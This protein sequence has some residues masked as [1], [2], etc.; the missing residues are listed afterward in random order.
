MAFVFLLTV[1][2]NTVQ[3]EVLTLDKCIEIGLKNN[4]SVIAAKNSYSVSGTQVYSAWST[5]LPSLSITT[6]TNQNWPVVTRQDLA[7]RL[8]S[9]KIDYSGRI[10]LS[11]SYGGLGL[12]T[13]ASIKQATH[14]KGSFYYALA[15]A[16]S[17]IVLSIKQNFYGV[18]KAKMLMDV[19]TEAVKRGEEGL[20]VAQSRYD[21]GSASM[22]DVLKAKVQFGNDKLDLVTQTNAYK[23]AMSNLAYAMGVNVNQE[24]EVNENLPEVGFELNFDKALNEALNSNPEYRKAQFDLYT[25]R[26][27]QLISYSY[28]IPSLS[29]SVSHTSSAGYLKDFTGFHGYNANRSIGASLDFNIFNNLGDYV[30][31]KSARKAVSTQSENLANSKNLVALNVRQAFLDIEL[32]QESKKLATESVASAQEDLDLVREK[33]NLGAATILDVLTSEVSLKQAQINQ[34]QALFDYNMAIARLEQALGR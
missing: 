7:G 14:E 6:S 30:R 17:N 25:A 12:A 19:A 32:A 29:F 26:D 4:Y 5:I 9:N 27:K 16:K 24:Y 15:G 18:L 8:T 22:S 20:R 28:F 31:L 13:Y 3:A 2:I 11:Q 1:F 21:L 23:I 10:S 34:V 33:Y